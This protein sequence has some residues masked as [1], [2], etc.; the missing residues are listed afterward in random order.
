LRG[1]F[2]LG[3]RV[4]VGLPRLGLA[5]ASFRENARMSQE[6]ILLTQAERHALY[7]I[8]PA[9]GGTQPPE[10]VQAALQAKGLAT[11]PREDGRRWLTV[12][13]DQVRLGQV[14]S[15]VVD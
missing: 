4:P 1:G 3:R 11:A 7:F 14:P 2:F 9:P 5:V 15:R 10:E 6:E 8:P 12:L 13:G